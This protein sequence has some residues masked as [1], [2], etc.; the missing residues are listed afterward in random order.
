[1][2]EFKISDARNF[3]NA[4]ELVLPAVA[5]SK[6]GRP[7][8]SSVLVEWRNDTWQMVATESH[9]LVAAAES[10]VNVIDE[11]TYSLLLN[12]PA[13]LVK[14]L[15]DELKPYGRAISGPEMTITDRQLF[16]G[17]NHLGGSMRC[18]L[19]GSMITLI[20]WPGEFPNYRQLFSGHK[21]GCIETFGLSEV[22]LPI[23]AKVQAKAGDASIKFS[24]GETNLKPLHFTLSTGDLNVL[25]LVVP[26]RFSV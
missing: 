11:P 6:D 3:L 21:P 15:K 25:G 22:T 20:T 5:P 18:E 1:M 16:S 9:V 8:L 7:I 24:M 14:W 12:E 10:D 13:R 26:V 19:H 23:L 2:P 4:L 17:H